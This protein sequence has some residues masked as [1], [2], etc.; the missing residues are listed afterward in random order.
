MGSF[1]KVHFLQIA[2]AKN[3][4][5]VVYW[6]R[7]KSTSVG[8]VL[9]KTL[10]VDPELLLLSRKIHPVSNWKGFLHATVPYSLHN[11]RWQ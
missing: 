8:S 2:N 11:N 10:R 5:V 9:L 4:K 7:I 1:I 3:V 6:H